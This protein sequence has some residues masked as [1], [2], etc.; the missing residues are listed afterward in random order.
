MRALISVAIALAVMAAIVI[1]IVAVATT[2]SRGATEVVARAPVTG[3][4]LS[5]VAF[6]LLF[7]LVAGVS[8][9]LIGGP[10]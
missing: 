2:L 5:K 9:G 10:G 6:V 7:A 8:S 3:T 1:G 4:T